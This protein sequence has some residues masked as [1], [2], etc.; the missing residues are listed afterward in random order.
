ME[1]L[2]KLLDKCDSVLF[3]NQPKRID[4][5]FVL[6]LVWH[7]EFKGKLYESEWNGFEDINDCVSD[8]ISNMEK[9]IQEN[10]IKHPEI[11]IVNAARKHD[12]EIK[13]FVINKS[14]LSVLNDGLKSDIKFEIPLSGEIH[15]NY[16]LSVNVV[17]AAE[18]ILNLSELAY[19]IAKTYDNIY[20]EEDETI[21]DIKEIPKKDRK[22][23]MNRNETDGRYGIWGHDLE[24]LVL[25]SI[26][27]YKNGNIVP[28]IGS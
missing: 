15:L 14:I 6:R 11:K 22:G 24:D 3:K 21:I 18:C 10:T 2:I 9:V 26:V 25:E 27:I 23:L 16:P 20:Q 12:N 19:I 17:I 13:R 8:F 1:K 4:G 28:I 5:E 7:A